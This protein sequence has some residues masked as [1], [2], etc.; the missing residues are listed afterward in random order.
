MSIKQLIALSKGK[1]KS[2][3]VGILNQTIADSIKIK[4]DESY[5]DLSYLN[6]NEQIMITKILL[7]FNVQSV[8]NNG[9]KQRFP[10]DEYKEAN[11]SLEH[12]HAQQSEGLNV[13]DAQKEWLKQHVESLKAIN[14]NNRLDDLINRTENAKNDK[15]LT[16]ITFNTLFQEIFSALTDDE[17]KQASG[18]SRSS[19]MHSLTNMALLKV[20]DNAALSNAVF[21]AKRNLI[22]EMDKQGQF[23]PF[24]TR[25]VFLKYYSPSKGNQIHFW[26]NSDRKAYRENMNEVLKTYLEIN[27]K[28]I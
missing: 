19:Y 17:D 22:I 12:I 7:L 1:T 18:E 25:M 11:W 28:E 26:S 15:D 9:S 21:D 16:T 24:C 23:I 4:D 5:M 8:C 20:S 27:G 6:K 3:F 14:D 10:F 13:K 2:D